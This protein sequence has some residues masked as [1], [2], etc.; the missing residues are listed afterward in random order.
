MSR[1]RSSFIAFVALLVLTG[2]AAAFQGA[3]FPGGSFK[4]YDGENNVSLW[5]DSTGALTAYVNNEAF[6]SGNWEAKADTLMFGPLQAPEGYGCAGDGKYLWSLAE[7]TL[8]VTLVSDECA[9]R[10]QYFTAL[11]WTRG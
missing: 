4:T 2:A 7:T 6:S 1:L 8:K 11:T 5:F 10:V 3:K 9:L